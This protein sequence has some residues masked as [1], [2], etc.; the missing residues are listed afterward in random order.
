MRH[1]PWTAALLAVA[2]VASAV[3][4]AVAQSTV[5]GT[6]SL[7]AT[8]RPNIV[9]LTLRSRDA[10]PTGD[11][12]TFSQPVEIERLGISPGQLQAANHSVTFALHRDAGTFRFEGSLDRGSG[13][14]DTTFVPDPAYFA[15]LRQHGYAVPTPRDEVTLAV[16][17]VTLAYADALA[18]AGFS[19]LSVA[20]LTEL[21]MANVT[22]EYARAIRAQ[23]RNAGPTDAITLRHFAVSPEYVA[24]LRAAG[25]PIAS[26]Q[27]VVILKEA[28]VDPAFVKRLS[29]RGDR[30]LTVDRILALKMGGSY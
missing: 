10:V 26:A 21:K 11:S 27:D 13:S 17:D 1:H 16:L 12:W 7:Q 3:Q 19:P 15:A 23:I 8:D 29:D 9:Q 14:G 18:A 30:G 4:A 25:A 6:W 28:G 5:P 22:P 2:V 20:Q 24:A